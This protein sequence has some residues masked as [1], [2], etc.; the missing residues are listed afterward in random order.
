MTTEQRY[1]YGL[2]RRKSA[3]AR[4]RLYPGEGT[5]VVNGKPMDEIIPR[6]SLRNE[7][8]RPLVATDNMTNFNIQVRV[9][10]GGVSGWAGAISHGVSRALVAYNDGNKKLLRA[11]GLLTR[12]ARVKERKKPGL[13]RARKAPQF[14]KR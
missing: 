8:L 3:I 1:F 6:E 7:I 2:G 14:T 9:E 5:V 11:E 10:G 12:D 4:V 13:K